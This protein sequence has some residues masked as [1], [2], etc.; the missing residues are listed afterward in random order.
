ALTLPVAKVGETYGV[1]IK[2]A[3][4]G[5]E[6]SLAIVALAAALGWLG[7]AVSVRRHLTGI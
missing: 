4:P 2:L 6:E 1:L 3:G 7:T 5:W